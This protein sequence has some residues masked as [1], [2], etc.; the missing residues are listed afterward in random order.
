M[1]Q[2][3]V[4]RQKA[5]LRQLRLVPTQTDCHSE[6]NIASHGHRYK[7]AQM[8]R[9]TKIDT[10]VD[11][12]AVLCRILWAMKAT[13]HIWH[14]FVCQSRREKGKLMVVCSL[15]IPLCLDTVP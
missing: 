4:Q 13:I 3:Y 14:A 9:I 8:H 11:Q 15:A 2:L 12:T 10:E 7:M 5:N 1:S 6:L